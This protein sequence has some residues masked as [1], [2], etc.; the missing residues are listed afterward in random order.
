V[1]T[2]YLRQLKQYSPHL[3]TYTH[4]FISTNINEIHIANFTQ[5]YQKHMIIFSPNL[6]ILSA[7]VIQKTVKQ[8]H[9][10]HLTFI[11]ADEWGNNDMGYIGKI[12]ASYQ[13]H[14]YDLQNWSTA[15]KTKQVRTFERNAQ[16]LL[17]YKINDGIALATYTT[18]MSV[19]Q[20]IKPAD[21]RRAN[22][23]Q[24]Y[25]LSQFL[26]TA[27]H[28]PSHYKTQY[29]VIY[30]FKKSTSAPIAVINLKDWSIKPLHNSQ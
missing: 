20:S 16:H 14:A 4:Y 18:L 13:F 21:Y 27:K 26:H 10:Q 7:L 17:G 11:G 29:Y 28:H 5:H 23:K 3:L 19:I 1:S 24:A 8:L 22:N 12:P 25:V 2:L 6:S 15:F 9:N 30:K